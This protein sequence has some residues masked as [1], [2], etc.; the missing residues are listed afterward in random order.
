MDFEKF[1]EFWGAITRGVNPSFPHQKKHTQK[2]QPKPTTSFFFKS[3]FPKTHPKWQWKNSLKK[4]LKSPLLGP[5]MMENVIFEILQTWIYLNLL[6][7]QNWTTQQKQAS[8]KDA[9]L[10]TPWGDL[11]ELRL[12]AGG[13]G[14]GERTHT[15]KNGHFRPCTQWNQNQ[16]QNPEDFHNAVRTSFLPPQ[17]DFIIFQEGHSP[18]PPPTQKLR[19]YWQCGTT[20]PPPGFSTAGQWGWHIWTP[21][22]PGCTQNPPMDP[23][24]DWPDWTPHRKI[25]FKGFH[26]Q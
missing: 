24:S 25:L 26:A 2:N 17:K 11:L 22:P 3:T 15:P 7:T 18:V 16:N 21:S 12:G 20:A 8:E 13:G 19:G 14:D 9:K 1:R 5:K 4:L 10:I 6:L 23:R